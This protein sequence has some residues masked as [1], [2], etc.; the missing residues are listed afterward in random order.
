MNEFLIIKKYF[1]K[2]SKKNKGTFGLSDDIFFDYQKKIALSIDTYNEET[3]FLNF[4]NPELVIKKALRSSI[5]DLVCKGISPKFYLIS[6]SGSKKHLS[7]KNISIQINIPESIIYK[8]GP[9]AGLAFITGIMG[10]FMSK[11]IPSDAAFTGELSLEGRIL[12]IGGLKE[13]LT[14]AYVSGIKTVYI[15]KENFPEVFHLQNQIKSA[16]KIKLVDHYEN[17]IEDMWKI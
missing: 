9:S 8:D 4:K 5:S 14:A 12:P 1:S 3:H 6:F 13:K 17:V 10:E 2:L 15:P 16:L 7:K 11:K